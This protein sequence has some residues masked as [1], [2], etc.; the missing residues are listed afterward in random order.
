[1][2]YRSIGWQNQ[3]IPQQVVNDFLL[4]DNIQKFLSALKFLSEK[5]ERKCTLN[6]DEKFQL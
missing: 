4:E 5:D 1:M 2:Y 3:Q 6:N